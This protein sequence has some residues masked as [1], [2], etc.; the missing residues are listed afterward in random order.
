MFQE[1]VGTVL[2]TG[3]L[4]REISTAPRFLSDAVLL[5]VTLPELQNRGEFYKGRLTS[6]AVNAFEVKS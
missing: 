5:S 1:F 6:F 4:R 3:G 2:H